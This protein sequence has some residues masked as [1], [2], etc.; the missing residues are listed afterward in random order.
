MPTATAQ[1]AA[2]M[3]LTA[4]PGYYRMMLGDFELTALFD[5]SAD[6]P[7]DEILKHTTRGKIDKALAKSFLHA[8]VET[9]VNAY[10]VNTGA[11]LILIDTG[12]AGFVAPDRMG[13]LASNLKASG[14]QPEQINEIYLTHMHPD[15]VGGLTVEGRM[16]FPNAILRADRREADVWLSQT[17]M[18]AAPANGKGFFKA[19]MATVTPYV[20]AGRFVP[21]DG[22]TQLTA[23]I[24]AMATPG[25]SA[26]HMTYVIESK[27]QKL[28]I[29]G[30]LVHIAA[31]QFADP[32]VTIEF[33]SD[34]KAAAA[35]RKQAFADAAR[36][37]YLVAAPHI[38]FPGLGH[39]RAE[40]K[41]Y[42]WVPID[43]GILR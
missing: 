42:V 40:G 31:V 43:Y 30:D 25:H 29:W 35:Q 36:N 14:Y 19:A 22:D 13:K 11:K 18:D 7:V 20:Q 5:G 24:K 16:M 27:G 6:L 15:H 2:P 1:P 9:S 12:S 39:V 26:G 10:L 34:S 21:F 41:S 38:A 8:P 17:R 3:A 37:R 23:G 33:D 32:T 28:V 4:S